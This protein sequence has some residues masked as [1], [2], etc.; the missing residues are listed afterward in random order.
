V[1]ESIIGIQSS[2]GRQILQDSWIALNSHDVCCSYFI[3]AK[4][5]K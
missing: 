1:E 3:Q 2:Q 5:R 4:S